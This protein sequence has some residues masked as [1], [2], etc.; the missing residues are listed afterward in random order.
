MLPRTAT[1]DVATSRLPC[2]AADVSL[3]NHKQLHRHQCPAFRCTRPAVRPQSS[4]RL[5]CR[6]EIAEADVGPSTSAETQAI[7]DFGTEASSASVPTSETWELDFS[8]RP[9]LDSRGKKRWELLICSPDRSWVYSKWFPNNKI[10]S[11]QVHCHQKRRLMAMQCSAVCPSTL[12][13]W[14]CAVLCLTICWHVRVPHFH[15]HDSERM[16]PCLIVVCLLQLKQALADIISQQG[17]QAPQR[18]RFFRGQMQTIISRA[19]T[20][21]DIKPVPSRRCFALIGGPLPHYAP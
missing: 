3:P 14:C 15:L 17:A 18:V 5:L 13:S 9:I 16:L 7:L 20:D 4:H 8:S 21:L 6:A 1:Q 11:T 10:N 12:S 19:L 2:A